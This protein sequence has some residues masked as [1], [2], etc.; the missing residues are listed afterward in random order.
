MSQIAEITESKEQLDTLNTTDNKNYLTEF[1]NIENTPFTI[2]KDETGYYGVIGNHR[3][4]EEA[5]ESEEECTKEVI[6]INWNRLIQVIWAVTEKFTK[7]ET[8]KEN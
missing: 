1:K 2:V 6:D 3:I 7:I 8:L 4:T 5:Y